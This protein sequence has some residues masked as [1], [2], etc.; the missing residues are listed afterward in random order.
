MIRLDA[1]LPETHSANGVADH[2]AEMRNM[3]WS[4]FLIVKGG[5]KVRSI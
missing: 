3:V 2:F 1:D 4:S 5:K